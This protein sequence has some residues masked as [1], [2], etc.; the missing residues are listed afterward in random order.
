[1]YLHAIILKKANHEV[2][3][4]IGRH[5][6][7]A[8]QFNDTFFLVRSNGISDKIAADAGIK[9]EDRVNDAEGVVFK[10]NGAHSGYAA[11][12]LWEWLAAEEEK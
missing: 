3:H 7:N 5:Y 12:S 10:L 1:M 4:R 2:T 8:Y 9:G 11:T 6:P